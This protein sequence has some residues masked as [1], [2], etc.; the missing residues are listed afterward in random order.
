MKKER[1]KRLAAGLLCLCMAGSIAGTQLV[2]AA[3]SAPVT[4]SLTMGVN[5]QTGAMFRWWV[6][7]AL[8]M[9]A[10]RDTV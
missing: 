7:A 10:D 1:L 3:T 2:T 8:P 5:Q 9:K 4:H 6:P